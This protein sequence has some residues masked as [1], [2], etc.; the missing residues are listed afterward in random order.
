MKQLEVKKLEIDQSKACPGASIRI[1]W[2]DGT[3]TE[4]RI[5]AD[6][7]GGS[8]ARINFRRQ[9]KKLHEWEEIVTTKEDTVHRYVTRG[10]RHQI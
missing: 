7:I 3:A 9:G 4:A 10:L 1:I 8:Y 2:D 6:T 5:F